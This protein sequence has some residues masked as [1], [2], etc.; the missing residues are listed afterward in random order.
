M[1]SPSRSVPLQST[2]ETEWLRPEKFMK[3]RVHLEQCPCRGHWSLRSMDLESTHHLGLWQTQ[4]GPSTVSTINT[5]QQYLFAVSLLPRSTTEQV[6]LNKWSSSPPY[7]R[8]DI[9]HWRDL[10]TEEAKINKEGGTAPEV[11]GA[12][13]QNPA[14]NAKTVFEGQL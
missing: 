6:S 8:V 14:V 10:Q 7:V 12:T 5:C 3:H 4:C 2:R 11:T 1:H 9:R 13:D